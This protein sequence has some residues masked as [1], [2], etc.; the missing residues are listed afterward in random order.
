MFT[1]LNSMNYRQAGK[2]FS[3]SGEIQQDLRRRNL[4][5]RP[6]EL[7]ANYPCWQGIRPSDLCVLPLAEQRKMQP[8]FSR[9]GRRH[10]PRSRRRPAKG[11]DCPL[12]GARQH[13]NV[14]ASH[15]RSSRFYRFRCRPQIVLEICSSFRTSL[16]MLVIFLP[17]RDPFPV[18][19]LQSHAKLPN[20]RRWMLANHLNEFLI[21]LHS[22][23][24]L[25][26][27]IGIKSFS[28]RTPRIPAAEEIFKITG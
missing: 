20:L 11:S 4:L 7:P 10:P 28:V 26:G 18:R 17:N 12:A 2:G 8:A 24:S 25:C 1:F 16:I 27:V 22:S 5:N 9:A 3:E 19:L 21:K 23:H 15:A 13:E 14:A 6:G